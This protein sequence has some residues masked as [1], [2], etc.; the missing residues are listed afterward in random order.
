M[1]KFEVLLPEIPAKEFDITEYGAVNGGKVS[2]TAAFAEAVQAASKAGGGKVVIPPGIWLTGPIELKSNI[3]LHAK[4]G[5][6]VLFDKN[7]EEYPVFLS[8]YEG[9]PRI[10]TV[11]PIHAKEAE[12][13]AI[14]RKSVV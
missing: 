5:A 7:A 1:D 3:E 6:L 10:R 14:D 8:D 13:I 9:L 11:S 2:N 4:R 12:N